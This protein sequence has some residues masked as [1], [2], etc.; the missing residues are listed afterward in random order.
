[1]LLGAVYHADAG[2]WGFTR[3]VQMHQPRLQT[4]IEQQLHMLMQHNSAIAG[5]MGGVQS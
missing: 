2:S 1:M 3:Q 4:V 5:R